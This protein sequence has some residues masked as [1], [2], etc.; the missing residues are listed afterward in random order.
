MVLARTFPA[1]DEEA[2]D[3]A[4]RALVRWS[5]ESVVDEIDSALTLQ[6]LVREFEDMLG[7]PSEFTENI[8]RLEP[9]QPEDM[10]WNRRSRSP[11]PDE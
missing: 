5:T 4:A 6:R 7:T 2:I 10:P 11:R 1:V 8:R 3:R 9:E